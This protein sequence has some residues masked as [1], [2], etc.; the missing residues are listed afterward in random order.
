MST[1]FACLYASLSS[2]A[3][4][5]TRLK[6]QLRTSR[7]E[8]R[9]TPYAGLILR[10]LTFHSTLFTTFVRAKFRTQPNIVDIRYDIVIAL[11]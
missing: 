6:T 2:G 9:V 3:T 1:V 8:S 11:F 5:T 7:V 10:S 4:T